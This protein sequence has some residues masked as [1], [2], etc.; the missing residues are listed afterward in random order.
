MTGVGFKILKV[1]LGITENETVV[2]TVH[3]P[4]DPNKVAVEILTELVYG[5]ADPK[6]MLGPPGLVFKMCAG[7]LSV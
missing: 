7:V 2:E 5:G 4:F 6:G 1:G 3:T